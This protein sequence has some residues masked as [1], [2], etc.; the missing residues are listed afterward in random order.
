MNP[1]SKILYFTATSKTTTSF[2]T[3]QSNLDRCVYQKALS[4]DPNSHSRVQVGLNRNNIDRLNSINHNVV[5]PS[6]A[7][8]ANHTSHRLSINSNRVGVLKPIQEQQQAQVL[9][10]GIILPSEMSFAEKTELLAK[11]YQ[12]EDVGFRRL[13]ENEERAVREAEIATAAAVNNTA[14]GLNATHIGLNDHHRS[15]VNQGNIIPSKH[16]H[17]PQLTF[18]VTRAHTSTFPNL[19]LHGPGI[20]SSISSQLNPL[21]HGPNSSTSPSSI[22]DMILANCQTSIKGNGVSGG[23]GDAVALSTGTSRHAD[24]N[25]NVHQSGACTVMRQMDLSR[26][27]VDVDP[28]FP[29]VLIPKGSRID[30]ISIELYDLVLGK[31]ILPSLPI[32]IWAITSLWTEEAWSIKS[33]PSAGTVI[34]SLDRNP[35]I[36]MMTGPPSYCSP[37]RLQQQQQQQQELLECLY[38][39]PNQISL[40]NGNGITI[41]V[42]FVEGVTAAPPVGSICDPVNPVSPVCTVKSVGLVP[43]RRV[44]VAGVEDMI[45]AVQHSVQIETGP[46]HRITAWN[47]QMTGNMGQ[48]P[49]MDTKV[50]EMGNMVFNSGTRINGDP[51]DR[52]SVGMLLSMAAVSLDSIYENGGANN[53][54]T[55]RDKGIVVVVTIDYNGYNVQSASEVTYNYNPTLIQ[56]Q[57]SVKTTFSDYNQTTRTLKR[58]DT[59]SIDIIFVQSGKIARSTVYG[60]LEAA[61]GAL[62]LFWLAKGVVW[63]VVIFVMPDRHEYRKMIYTWLNE[64]GSYKSLPTRELVQANFRPPPSL[65]P[66]DNQPF[67]DDIDQN[68]THLNIIQESDPITMNAEYGGEKFMTGSSEAKTLVDL[69]TRRVTSDSPILNRLFAP[70]GGGSKTGVA[71]SVSSGVIRQP[72][73]Q[74]FVSIRCPID[75]EK[76]GLRDVEYGGGDYDEQRQEFG[77]SQEVVDGNGSNCDVSTYAT[78]GGSTPRGGFPSPCVVASPLREVHGLDD[79]EDASPVTPSVTAIG[80]YSTESVITGTSSTSTK[81]R[82]VVTDTTTAVASSTS[83]T[84]TFDITKPTGAIAALLKSPSSAEEKQYLEEV[85]RS[86]QSSMNTTGVEVGPGARQ[87]PLLNGAT[88]MFSSPKSLLKKRSLPV[89]GSANFDSEYVYGDV[90]PKRTATN[91]SIGNRVIAPPSSPGVPWMGLG[92]GGNG[93]GNQ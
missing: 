62:I 38:L 32:V 12:Q 58:T 66:K 50:T 84:S 13:V 9:R 70:V 34:V 65:P 5:N 61:A 67:V 37:Q 15:S 68:E 29:G 30:R 33:I 45:L 14:N 22:R 18:N 7:N 52:L 83:F 72:Q 36:D 56:G 3:R 11:H 10:S 44:Y 25:I 89:P 6:T 51:Y 91:E 76:G 79:M 40:A 78:C 55:L 41:A 47:G 93:A 27:D 16:I 2:R 90:T 86:I 88:R 64:S 92:F 20:S 81:D 73:P 46:N 57:T 19:T 28:K 82:S 69:P 48:T 75:P 53:N 80:D 17:T 59:A 4:S 71:S 1:K 77:E 87:S 35:S 31:D 54:A 43:T 85:Q 39:D 23:C 63:L 49:S 42:S 74:R 26:V 8:A 21:S 60:F 24:V